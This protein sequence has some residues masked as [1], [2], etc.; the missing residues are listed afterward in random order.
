MRAAHS[1]LTPE[2]SS[3]NSRHQESD[4]H[5]RCAGYW[6]P[7]DHG[8]IAGI[9]TDDECSPNLV[10]EDSI[11]TTTGMSP[12][13]ITLDEELDFFIRFTWGGTIR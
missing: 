5:E 8:R 1:R 4:A 11:P 13:D 7:P 10:L 3:K 6:G 2:S 12:G 9:C